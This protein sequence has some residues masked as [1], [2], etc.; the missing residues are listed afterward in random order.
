[1]KIKEIL[2][3]ENMW[4]LEK[5]TG[6]TSTELRLADDDA[7]LSADAEKMFLHM[8]EQRENNIPLQYILQKW[9]FMGLDMI[10]RP[11]VLIP[12]FDTEILAAEVISFLKSAKSRPLHLDL[13][14]GSGC[15]GIAIAHYCPTARVSLSDISP[16]ALALARENAELNEVKVNFIQS[17]LF[18]NIDGRFNC[19]SANPP[20]IP[21]GEIDG[22]SPE[23][24]NEPHSALDGGVDGLDFYRAIIPQSKNHLKAKGGLFL[25]IGA[26]QG[27]AVSGMLKDH[28]FKAVAIIKDLEHRHRVVRGIK[29]V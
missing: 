8:L 4:L 23:V 15:V 9:D 13:C 6:L 14:T 1:M 20:Y 11:G 27:K 26:N 24:K 28:G 5:A 29:D 16:E 22:L 19:I 12:R 18:S 17:D 21:S 3:R 25:E 7:E 10:C 2:N